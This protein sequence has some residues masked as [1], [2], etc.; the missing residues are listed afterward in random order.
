MN[1]KVHIIRRASTHDPQGG[2]VKN[3]LEAMGQGG[4]KGVRV[5]KFID[6][7]LSGSSE[8]TAPAELRREFTRTFSDARL[9]QIFNPVIE[10]LRLEIDQ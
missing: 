9:G 4:I 5:G 7:E 8:S 2:A 3:A 1:I 10:E 6:I